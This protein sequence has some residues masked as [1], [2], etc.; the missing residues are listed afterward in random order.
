MNQGQSLQ[1]RTLTAVTVGCLSVLG[2]L[3]GFAASGLQDGNFLPAPSDLPLFAGLFAAGSVLG[4]VLTFFVRT[5]G[6]KPEAAEPAKSPSFLLAALLSSGSMA[7]FA[8]VLGAALDADLPSQLRPDVEGLVLGALLTV[9]LIAMLLA[10]MA[11]PLPFLRRFR[12]RQIGDFT[13][14][15]VDFGWLAV[16]LISFGAGF[17]EELLFRGVV[18]H[19]LTGQIGTFLGIAATSVLFGIV[20]GPRLGY[21]LISGLIGAYLGTAYALSGSLLA[22]ALAHFLYDIYALRVTVVAVR[23]AKRSQEQR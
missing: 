2:G 18:Q 10:I 20:H 15:N 12:D 16:I 22:V 1:K 11:A 17:G 23:R 4:F 6:S 14:K 19:W 5:S 8:L 7:V 9:P 3:F 21:I 13:E